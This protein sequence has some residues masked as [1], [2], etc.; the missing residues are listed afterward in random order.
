MVSNF[1]IKS[2]T[3]NMNFNNFE[4][5]NS[6]ELSESSNCHPENVGIQYLTIENNTFLSDQNFH[7]TYKHILIFYST[8]H[9]EILVQRNYFSLG[10][11]LINDIST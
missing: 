11:K 10:K 2:S 1:T 5:V 8:L 9:S 7:G 6:I 4:N 3:F